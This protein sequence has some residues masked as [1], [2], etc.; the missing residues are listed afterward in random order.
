MYY[1]KS[2][3]TAPLASRGFFDSKGKKNRIKTNQKLSNKIA[4]NNPRSY[5]NLP[6][7]GGL[8][9]FSSY[10]NLKLQTKKKLFIIEL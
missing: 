7:Y 2:I 9:R 1:F 5:V 6:F 8:K 4:Q 10:R 3:A